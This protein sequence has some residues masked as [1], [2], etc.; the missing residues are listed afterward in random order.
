MVV[1]FGLLV[2]VKLFDFVFYGG[3]G[4]FKLE[5]EEVLCYGVVKMNVD[6]DI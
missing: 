1:K 2:D 6:I 4:L 3:L 5:I